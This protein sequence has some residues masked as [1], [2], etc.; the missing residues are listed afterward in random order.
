MPSSEAARRRQDAVSGGPGKEFYRLTRALKLSVGL[1]DQLNRAASSIALNLAEGRA[2]STLAD[3]LKFFNIAFGSL[4]ESQAILILSSLE[5][6]ATWQTLDRL[7]AQLYC[8]TK[9]AKG[10]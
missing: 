9:N 10:G 7:A 4:R 8:L 2:K 1:K 3:Q 5:G 6:S